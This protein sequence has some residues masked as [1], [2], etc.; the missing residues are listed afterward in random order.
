MQ[1]E[2]PS[3]SVPAMFIGAG[4]RALLI[5]RV[6]VEVHR[7]L[8]AGGVPSIVLKGPSIANWLYGPDE[9]RGYGDSDLLVPHR[10]WDRAG[11]VLESLGFQNFLASMAHP[12][13]ESYASDPWFRNGEDIDLHS[14]LYGIG[15]PPAAVWDVLCR[16]T[17]RM[18]IG[19][20]E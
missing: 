19:G 3:P 9:V 18:A 5:D 20:A 10:D 6:T 16:K 15:V 7:A 11:R 1:G 8:E 13:M 14:T 12:R 2:Q 17:V 4:L